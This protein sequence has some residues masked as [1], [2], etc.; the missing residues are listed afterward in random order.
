MRSLVFLTQLLLCRSQPLAERLKQVPEV[1]TF[2]SG[3]AGLA[4]QMEGLSF[5]VCWCSRC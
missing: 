3:H 1:N 4:F 5:L 2:V